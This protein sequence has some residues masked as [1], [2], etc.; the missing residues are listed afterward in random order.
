MTSELATLQAIRLKG[1][2]NLADIA[3]ATN[4]AEN[5]A[6]VILRALL[7]EDMC[8]EAEECFSLTRSGRDRL[9][10]LLT[11]EGKCIDR[12]ALSEIY[13]RFDAYNSDLK[14]IVT[15][16]QLKNETTPNDHVD[17]IYDAGVVGRLA[18]LH[19]KFKP[20]LAEMVEIAPRLAAYPNRFAAALAK[21]QC[22]EYIWF[23]RP[24]IDSYHTV[25]FEMHEDLIGLS[26]LTRAGES[27]A[28]RAS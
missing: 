14:R 8:R 3:W 15:D 23:A 6:A 27:A 25:W 21:I 5:E 12:I 16:W 18:E 24:M 17:V 11:Q 26:G 13:G 9:N 20:E 1:K 4:T 19:E 7:N 10:L 2:P 22:G 28:G